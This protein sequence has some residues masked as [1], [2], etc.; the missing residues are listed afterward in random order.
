[1]VTRKLGVR[2]T[3]VGIAKPYFSNP[4]TT[5]KEKTQ[6]RA[7][8]ISRGKIQLSEHEVVLSPQRQATSCHAKLHAKSSARLK[9]VGSEDFVPLY[10]SYSILGAL[11]SVL[12]G[13]GC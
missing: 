11:G 4:T 5:A 6:G 7:L 2:K 12:D 1:M 9:H 3:A 8:H 13:A 10:P